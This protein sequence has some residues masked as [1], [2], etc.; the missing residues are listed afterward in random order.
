MYYFFLREI[1]LVW[2]FF[3]PQS[4]QRKHRDYRDGLGDSNDASF[5]NK[6]CDKS[7]VKNIQY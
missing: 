1:C 6:I 2:G 3:L 4:A 5:V 7:V